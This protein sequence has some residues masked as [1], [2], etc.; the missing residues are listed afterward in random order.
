MSY[1]AYKHIS[2][3]KAYRQCMAKQFNAHTQEVEDQLNAK[4]TRLKG[5]HNRKEAE[6]ATEHQNH[7]QAAHTLRAQIGYSKKEKGKAIE[8][9]K[10]MTRKN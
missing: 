4:I 6:W 9:L 5:E 10:T 3:E 2:V 8:D 1:P 7:E